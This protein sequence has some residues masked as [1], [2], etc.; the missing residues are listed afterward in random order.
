VRS[1]RQK[2]QFVARHSIPSPDP[3]AVGRTKEGHG[4]EAR[5]SIASHGGGEVV[6]LLGVG[7]LIL[8]EFIVG[9]AVCVAGVIADH[10]VKSDRLGWRD[11][12][13]VESET[14]QYE[15]GCG[16]RLENAL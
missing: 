2:Y 1:P 15:Q 7:G 13:I 4:D 11:E 8:Y 5:T 9:I 16:F 12:Q 14:R 6:F 10:V 3:Q